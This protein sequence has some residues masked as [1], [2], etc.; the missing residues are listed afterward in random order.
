MTAISDL[1]LKTYTRF[2]EAVDDINEH[3]KNK[4]SFQV[5]LVKTVS[6]YLDSGNTDQDSKL[7]RKSICRW[8]LFSTGCSVFSD[9]FEHAGIEMESEGTD[10]HVKGCAFGAPVYPLFFEPEEN[11][12]VYALENGVPISYDFVIRPASDLAS[13][14]VS[15]EV[16]HPSLAQL[17]S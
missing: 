3:L 15:C 17:L 1:P 4:E 5:C 16:T 14:S 10:R 2:D 6:P 7:T 8:V 11:T 9:M 12:V 13:W